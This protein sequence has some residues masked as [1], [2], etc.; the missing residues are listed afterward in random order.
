MDY[1]TLGKIV[2]ATPW[3]ICLSIRDFRKHELP[4]TWIFGGILVM[5]AIALGVGIHYAVASLITAFLAALPHE[6]RYKNIRDMLLRRPKKLWITEPSVGFGFC[7]TVK[8]IR[9]KLLYQ[10]NRGAE[11]VAEGK[12]TVLVV[13]STVQGEGKTTAA[14]NLAIS[15]AQNSKKVLLVE[16]DLRNPAAPLRKMHGHTAGI[17][18]LEWPAADERLLLSAG[19]DGNIIG[20]AR[21][22]YHP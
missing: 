11:N 16:G 12:G 14:V 10:Q 15:L 2:L 9:T 8:K 22:V 4:N 21:A 6:R 20:S 3:L 13:T 5:L 19:N 17:N 18:C 1:L 7:E